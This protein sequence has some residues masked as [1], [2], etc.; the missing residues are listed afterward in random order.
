[1]PPGGDPN[2]DLRDIGEAAT[3]PDVPDPKT[4]REQSMAEELAKQHLALDLRERIDRIHQRRRYALATFAG[5]LAWLAVVL[6]LVAAQGLGWI[7]IPFRA[8]YKFQLDSS[9]MVAL[10][11]T[12]TANIVAV[13]LVVMKFIFPGGKD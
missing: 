1:M 12:T 6:A 3:V 5:V 8:T 4:S 2:P 9:V 10:L 13:L 7:W 11:A